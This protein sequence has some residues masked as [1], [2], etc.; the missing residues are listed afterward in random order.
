M[1][2]G[3]RNKLLALAVEKWIIGYKKCTSS[4]LRKGR[5]GR[6]EVVFSAGI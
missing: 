1:A 3:Q 2:C 4:L 6:T 5:E